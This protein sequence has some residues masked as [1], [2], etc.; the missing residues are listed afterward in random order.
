MQGGYLVQEET[1][2]CVGSI[3]LS[4]VGDGSHNLWV[5]TKALFEK[6]LLTNNITFVETWTS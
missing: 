6:Y 3:T 1:R 2:G 5:E 4:N